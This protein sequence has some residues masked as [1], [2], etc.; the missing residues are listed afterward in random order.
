MRRLYAILSLSLIVAAAA[1]AVPFA[2]FSPV[3]VS[4]GDPNVPGQ[5][6]LGTP[7]GAG[8]PYQ[9]PALPANATWMAMDTSAD[10]SSWT[11]GPT[12]PLTGGETG[13]FDH[14]P[15]YEAPD[16]FQSTMIFFRLRALDAESVE[17]GISETN[18][19]TTVDAPGVADAPTFANVVD[20][21]DGTWDFDII[22]PAAYPS[23]ANAWDM[24]AND[25][26]N[27]PSSMVFENVGLSGTRHFQ[28]ATDDQ[29]RWSLY[30]RNIYVSPGTAGNVGSLDL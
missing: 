10:G 17:I 2:F 30:S 23:D 18:S 27:P 29:Q 11:D 7:T 22:A 25:Q 12:Y 9:I 4:T 13:I 20:N 28:G 15:G 16:G 6:I 3:R 8:I 24:W 1:A 19:A 26:G 5:V 14:G 21:G